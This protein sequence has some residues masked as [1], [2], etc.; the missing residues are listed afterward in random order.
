MTRICL[1]S[2]K[3]KKIQKKSVPIFKF[4]Y[5]GMVPQTVKTIFKERTTAICGKDSTSDYA[6][7]V[8]WSIV[9]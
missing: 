5:D 7:A 1:S 4:G 2:L 3:Y 9:V 6:L 8:R